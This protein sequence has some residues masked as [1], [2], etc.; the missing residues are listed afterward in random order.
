MLSLRSRP[1]LCLGFLTFGMSSALAVDGVVLIDQARALAGNVTPGD[2]PGFPVTITQR[3]SY[4]LSGNL[5]IPDL[6]TTGIDIHSSFVTIDLNGFSIIGPNDCSGAT[7]LSGLGTGIQSGDYLPN[8]SRIYFNIAIRNGTIQGMGGAGIYVFGDAVT[9][10]HMTLRSNG[11]SGVFCVRRP[12]SSVQG[13][14]I[15]R[16]NHGALNGGYGFVID[17]GVVVGNTGSS[18]RAGGIWLLDGVLMQNFVRNNGGSGISLGTSAGAAENVSLDNT[19]RDM[20]GGIPLGK[21]LCKDN[22]C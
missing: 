22:S 19:V 11:G 18:N 1:V 15:V 21:N 12:P 16:H 10:E 6:S 4:R 17:S 2:A 14:V 7:C 20:G 3:G 9:I 8:P 5:T 13:N